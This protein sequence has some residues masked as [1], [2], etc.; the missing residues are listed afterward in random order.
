MELPRFT[1]KEHEL[2]N[3]FDR[4]M[5]VL[6]HLAKLNNLP[7]ALRNRVFEKLFH[8]AEI[9]KLSPKERK[10]Y[11]QSL[12]N[13]RDMYLIENEFKSEIKR[14]EVK[15]KE[16]KAIIRKQGIDLKKMSI[17]FQKQNSVIKISVRI[18]LEAG[19]SVQKIADSTGLS[20]MEI[21]QIKA[22]I[23]QD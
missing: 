21:E 9:L 13:Y 7:E 16:Q 12:K 8:V 19:V 14:K 23:Q 17:D 3:N 20:I 10:D 22:R 2:Q 18:L 11:D 1:K 5:Y 4:W 15:L 6:K